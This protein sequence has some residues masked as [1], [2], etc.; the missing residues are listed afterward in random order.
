MLKRRHVVGGGLAATSLALA[1][2]L[3]AQDRST[4]EAHW[5]S[6]LTLAAGSAGGTFAIYAEVWGQL[7]ARATGVNISTRATQGGAQNTALVNSNEAELGQVA[8]GVAMQGWE[9]TGE[10]TGGQRFREVR[11]LFPMFSSPFFFATQTSTGIRSI[12]DLNGRTIGV[13]PRGGF[14]GNYIP[15]LLEVLDITPSAI[16]FGNYSDQMGQAADGLLDVIGTA[17][18][19]PAPA[20]REFETRRPATFFGFEPEQ[21]ATLV[22]HMP[23]LSPAIVPAG[24]YEAQTEDKSTVTMWNFAIAHQSLPDDLVYEI[25]KAVMENHEQLVQG[26]S[27]AR[28]SLPENAVANSFMTWHP[29]AARYFN[30]LGIELPSETL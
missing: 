19:L 5:P 8:M 14:P 16:R 22:E 7:A 1:G 30:E 28:E 23:E 4:P 3:R 12:N 15:M 24:T 17:A 9:G 6:S 27:A 21:V 2:M 26:H 11:A 29:G 13:G 18:G 10:W 25:V 20:Y